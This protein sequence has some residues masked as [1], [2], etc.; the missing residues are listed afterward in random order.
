MK[1]G[2]SKKRLSTQGSRGGGAGALAKAG[3]EGGGG[4]SRAS[5][6]G[7]KTTSQDLSSGTVII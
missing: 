1:R 5:R 7:R 2:D 3:G 6:K 4:D